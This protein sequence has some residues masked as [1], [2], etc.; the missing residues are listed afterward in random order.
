MNTDGES[1]NNNQRGM[2]MND[3]RCTM[4]ETAKVAGNYGSPAQFITVTAI[5]SSRTRPNMESAK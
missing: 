1:I 2:A 3:T 5:C 4:G